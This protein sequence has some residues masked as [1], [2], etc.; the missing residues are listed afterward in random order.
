MTGLSAQ[1]F[2]QTAIK[3]IFKGKLAGVNA[4][5]RGNFLSLMGIKSRKWGGGRG[6][7]PTFTENSSLPIAGK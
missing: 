5:R 3:P 2:G 6:K 7:I 4:F 1:M